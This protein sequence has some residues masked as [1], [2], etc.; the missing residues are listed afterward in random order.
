MPSDG[1]RSDVAQMRREIA[2][3]LRTHERFTLDDM[4][5]H[6][7][8]RGAEP[9][10]AHLVVADWAR[11]V[12]GDARAE[13]IEAVIADLDLPADVWQTHVGEFKRIQREMLDANAASQAA[14]DR[15]VAAMRRMAAALREHD[16]DTPMGLPEALR[17]ELLADVSAAQWEHVV[18]RRRAS[19]ISAYVEPV[20]T[21]MQS[22]RPET[23]A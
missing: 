7:T 21:A 18:T 23:D 15:A 6:L 14:T 16:A 9:A 22:R 4:V 19:A 11:E 8:D 1:E 13:D 10:E 3:F 17:D 20:I 5:E 2:D 12:D